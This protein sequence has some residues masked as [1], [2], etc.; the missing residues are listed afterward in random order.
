MQFCP[1]E[2]MCHYYFWKL[3]SRAMNWNWLAVTL[4]DELVHRTVVN[5]SSIERRKF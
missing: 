1:H 3:G 4:S 2:K 5:F